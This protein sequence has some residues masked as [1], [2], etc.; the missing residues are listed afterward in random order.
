[1]SKYLLDFE[2]PLKEIEKK[3]ESLK[4]TSIQTGIDVDSGVMQLLDNLNNKK[5][6]IYNNLSRWQRVQLSRHP[7]R[8]YFNDFIHRITTFWY[9]LHGDRYYSDDLALIGGLAKIDKLSVIVIGQEKGRGTK[10]KIKRNFGMVH[11]E[12]YRKALRLMKLAE[13][14]NLPVLSIIDTIGAYPGIGAEERGQAR[15]IAQ[16]IYE[17][18]NLK[19]P[20]VSVVIGEGASGGA[21]GI[22]V[23][24]KI[25][26]FE[27]TWYSVISPEGC[28]SILFHDSNRAEEAANA[29][30]VTARDLEKIGIADEILEEPQGGNHLDYDQAALVLKNSVTKHFNNLMSLS[31]EELINKRMQKYDNIGEWIDG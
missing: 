9:E 20:I 5:K 18:I 10:A 30:Q 27:N 14:F 16:N 15:A 26:C 13:K 17:M 12:G 2:A 29:M 11:P 25:L 21:L 22:G 19:V 3:I 28:A 6:E 7:L 8:P 31:K 24:D 1:M 23:A 4:S